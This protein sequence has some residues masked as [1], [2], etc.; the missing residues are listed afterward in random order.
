MFATYGRVWGLICLLYIS[1]Q[2]MYVDGGNSTYPPVPP[3]YVLTNVVVLV[4]H[5]DRIQITK[6]FGTAVKESEST[7]RFW[8]SKLPDESVL[9][10]IAGV[11]RPSVR[12]DASW[13]QLRKKLYSGWDHMHL[14][15]GQLTQLG[16]NQM[17]QVG[18][19]IRDR[20]LGTFIPSKHVDMSE[21]LYCRSTNMCRTLISL[22]SLLRGLLIDTLSNHTEDNVYD[23]A[24]EMY[25][26]AYIPKISSRYKYQETM[27]PHADGA[28]DGMTQRRL[29]L[30]KSNY[31][32]ATDPPAF[33]QSLELKMR[34]VFGI[35]GQI[36]WLTWLNIMEILT[37]FRSHNVPLPRGITEAHV[38]ATNQYVSWMWGHLYRDKE[39]V[40]FAVGRFIQEL[41]DDLYVAVDLSQRLSSKSLPLQ[42]TSKLKNEMDVEV[43][44]RISELKPQNI[45]FAGGRRRSR[46][47]QHE[48]NG[49]ALYADADAYKDTFVDTLSGIDSN[50]NSGVES[51][52]TWVGDDHDGG[53]RGGFSADDG[54]EEEQPHPPQPSQLES[55]RRGGGAGGDTDTR[56]Y[57]R[58][59]TDTDTHTGTDIGRGR[60]E[61]IDKNRGRTARGTA[62]AGAS[63]QQRSLRGEDEEPAG[64]SDATLSADVG[65]VS[66]ELQRGGS[67]NP[68][69]ADS[70]S[71]SGKSFTSKIS[72]T[73]TEALRRSFF[74]K[75]NPDAIDIDAPALRNSPDI[76]IK[77]GVGGHNYIYA[78]KQ[79]VFGSSSARRGNST[80]QAS[81]AEGP[82]DPDLQYRHNTTVRVRRDYVHASVLAP[83][84]AT[85]MLVY[86]GHD[87]TI[88]PLMIIFGIYKGAGNSMH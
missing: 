88:V 46:R 51:S 58:T 57:T 15:Y 74:G 8:K 25:N 3:E 47:L 29:D 4:R 7:E 44:E 19:V 11:A 30:I 77:K 86:S 63:A 36:D 40:R 27:Y 26:K 24:N 41:I 80:K 5:G 52:S 20:Y 61:I 85:K 31:N 1:L 21:F 2:C 72:S 53:R 65:D 73:I 28:C 45:A 71:S 78:T 35:K 6:H 56:T 49:T 38:N 87:A 23:S 18:K 84:P 81:N 32:N 22:R 13:D 14:P 10:S 43:M 70:S 82:G 60:K 68:M 42:M 59:G 69:A 83:T 37:C 50:R 75:G 62:R 67:E 54:V 48:S 55:S 12:I 66:R 64:V 79:R 33:H 34:K 17:K 39:L 16:V 76:T 9:R